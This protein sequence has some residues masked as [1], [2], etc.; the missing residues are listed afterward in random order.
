MICEKA[1]EEL[2]KDERKLKQLILKLKAGNPKYS[3]VYNGIEEFGEK[4]TKELQEI[5]NKEYKQPYYRSQVLKNIKEFEFFAKKIHEKNYGISDYDEKIVKEIEKG[6]NEILVLHGASG[7]GKSYILNRIYYKYIGN[8]EYAT[9]MYFADKN[10]YA[11]NTK[12]I[13][14]TVITFLENEMGRDCSLTYESAEELVVL[15]QRFRQLMQEYWQKFRKKLLVFVDAMEQM[16]AEMDKRIC[17]WIPK[18]MNPYFKVIFTWNEN[19]I[20]LIRRTSDV[21]IENSITEDEVRAQIE[22]YESFQRKEVLSIKELLM[23]AAKKGNKLSLA[24]LLARMNMLDGSDFSIIN[25]NEEQRNTYISNVLMQLADSPNMCEEIIKKANELFRVEG[26]EHTLAYLAISKSGLREKDIVTLMALHGIQWKVYEFSYLRNSL[27]DIFAEGIEGE[28]NFAH[29]EFRLSVLKNLADKVSYANRLREY[30]ITLPVED[31]ML[32][33]NYFSLAELC[34]DYTGAGKICDYLGR[35]YCKIRGDS[36]LEAQLVILSDLNLVWAMKSI[37][38]YT[39]TKL[40][41]YKEIL[42]EIED[43]GIDDMYPVC[44]YMAQLLDVILTSK[45][46]PWACRI[47]LGYLRDFAKKYNDSRMEEILLCCENGI[48]YSYV[49]EGEFE[50]GKA[51]LEKL[52]RSCEDYYQ[53][54]S[55][56]VKAY[57]VYFL[58]MGR[59]AMAH[60][61]HGEKCMKSNNQKAQ[62]KALRYY[63]ECR[64]IAQKVL[65][66]SFKFTDRVEADQILLKTFNVLKIWAVVDGNKITSQTKKREELQEVFYKKIDICAKKGSNL[67]MQA[68]L[69]YVLMTMNQKLMHDKEYLKV[70][71]ELKKYADYA[72]QLYLFNEEEKVYNLVFNYYQICYR[73]AVLCIATGLQSDWED[74]YFAM[75][76]VIYNLAGMRGMFAANTYQDECKRIQLFFEQMPNVGNRDYE[77]EARLKVIFEEAKKLL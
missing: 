50:K 49:L 18:E 61:R 40:T 37:V 64:L 12:A 14:V 57:D 54:N 60:M 65:E 3:F 25:Q 43:L 48:A 74:L 26:I 19:K 5:F 59:L 30:L 70:Q 71:A 38:S 41:V 35:K 51:E 44:N 16:K 66:E 77:R 15:K 8:P 53:R 46:D 72:E 67:G 23:N 32:R 55:A 63:E 24:L 58:C 62:N 42:Q 75:E 36:E 31:G 47:C 22:G 6:E 33:E 34:G 20:P 45:E 69:E 7:C 10:R 9:L 17:D 1:D 27:S 56:L 73:V 39:R 76:K 21:Y 4:L 68:L 52:R 2:T 13:L 28:I 29:E 11:E